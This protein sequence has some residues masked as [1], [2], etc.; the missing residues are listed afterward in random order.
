MSKS[1]SFNQW[2]SLYGIYVIII[3]FILIVYFFYRLSKRDQDQHQYDNATHSFFNRDYTKGRPKGPYESKGE[4]MCKE[5][6]L[7][8]FRRP[9]KKIRPNILKNDLTGSNMEIDLYND[10]LKL[11]IEFNGRQHYEFVPHFHKNKQSFQ[12][13]ILRDAL[14]ERK[15]K[16]NGIRLIIVPHTIKLSRIEQFIRNEAKKLGFIV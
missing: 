9:F 3:F 2:W 4:L 11:G 7:K 5:A 13:Q 8:I 12:D 6:A 10:E 16:E 1:M 14:K 15:C